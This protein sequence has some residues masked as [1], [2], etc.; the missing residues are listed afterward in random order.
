MFGLKPFTD[1]EVVDVLNAIAGKVAVCEEIADVD[2][3]VLSQGAST[4]VAEPTTIQPKKQIGKKVVASNKPAELSFVTKKDLIDI[5]SL[6]KE[7][8]DKK[9]KVWFWVADHMGS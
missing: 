9:Q 2:V 6:V 3:K 1:N 4:F 5:E 8:A 7:I